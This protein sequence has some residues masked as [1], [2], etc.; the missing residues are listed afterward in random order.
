MDV[1][2]KRKM[3][4]SKEKEEGGRGREEKVEGDK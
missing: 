4:E 1:D 3:K 2:L